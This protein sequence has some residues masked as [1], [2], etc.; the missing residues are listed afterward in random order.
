MSASE[1]MDAIA[2]AWD[3]NRRDLVHY[4]TRLL[5]DADA[6]ND[7]VQQ[8]ALRAL[9]ADNAPSDD[10]GLRKWLFRIISNLAID[11]LRRRGTWSETT[12]IE[13]R[14]AA[15]SDTEFVD[16]SLRLRGSQEMSAIAR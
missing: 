5:A 6:A 9:G 15:E 16:A 8:A 10:A 3:R 7:V 11:E 2:Q 13:A 12:L 4:A 1:R 14:A